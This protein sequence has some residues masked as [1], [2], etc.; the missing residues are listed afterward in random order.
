MTQKK[1]TLY[2]IGLG[3]GDPELVTVKASKILSRLKHVFIPR[4]RGFETGLASQIASHYISSDSRKYDLEY[5]LGNDTDE[6]RRQWRENCRQIC[7]VLESGADVGFLTIGDPMVYSTYIYLLEAMK[8]LM[9]GF[10]SITIPGVSAFLAAASLT[11]FPL[12]V[13]GKKLTIFPTGDDWTL[14]EKEFQQSGSLV[15][16]KIGRRR[17]GPLLEMIEKNRNVKRLAFVSRAGLDGEIALTDVDAIRRLDTQAG[18]LSVLLLEI[19]SK[20]IQ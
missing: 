7:N 13:S 18:N 1:G 16:M 11:N 3:P 4:A 12:G 10:Q 9:P 19:D 2:G 17:I 14:I 6:I 8:E 15:F 5:P 20:G